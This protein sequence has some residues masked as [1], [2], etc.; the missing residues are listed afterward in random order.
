[1]NYNHILTSFCHEFD[2]LFSKKCHEFDDVFS[3]FAEISLKTAID[4]NSHW[5]D[6]N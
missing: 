4:R 3:E 5:H 1:M 2:N 6:E